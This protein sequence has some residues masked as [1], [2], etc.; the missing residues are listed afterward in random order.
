[1]APELFHFRPRF[2]A[3][4]WTASGLGAGA[5]TL[6]SLGLL[7]PGQLIGWIV[8]GIGAALG[9][10]YAVSPAWRLIVAV[11]EHGLAV[12]RGE[13]PRFQLPWNEVVRVV[14]SPATST[15][16]VDGGSPARSLLV[17]GYGATAPYDLERKP[18][19]CR[20]IVARVPADR[21][22]EVDSLERYAAAVQVTPP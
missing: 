7:G 22:I 12:R 4:A 8:G 13:T 3:L 18:E 19:L 14:W 2:R 11:D 5:M 1:M 15:M 10:L 21:V 16:F 9:P 6:A 20:A 17:P